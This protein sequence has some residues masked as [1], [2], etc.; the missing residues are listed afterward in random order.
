MKKRISA[1]IISLVIVLFSVLTVCRILKTAVPFGVLPELDI[2]NMVLICGVALLLDHLWSGKTNAADLRMPIFA[3]LT[4]GL[5][6]YA[7]GFVRLD[8]VLKLGITGGVVFGLAAW[9]YDSIADRLTTGPASK[10][11]PILSILGLYLAA[12]CFA[13][14]VI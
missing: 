12:Q 4:F 8:D 5:L 7:A 2:P 9:I 1:P 3:A 6:P 14:I 13:G 11:T 10:A